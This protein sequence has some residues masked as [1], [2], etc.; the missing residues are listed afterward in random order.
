MKAKSFRVYLVQ[1]HDGNHTG[2]LLRTWDWIFDRPAPSAY[3][4]SEAEVLARLEAE[5]QLMLASGQDDIARYLWDD[6]FELRTIGIDIHPQSPVRG[7]SVIGKRPIPLRITYLWSKVGEA[8]YRIMVPRFSWW[9]IVEDLSIAREVLRQAVSSTLLGESPRSVFHY[10][11]DGTESVKTWAPRSL[12]GR[13]AEEDEEDAFPVTRSVSEELVERAA[14]RKLPLM[15]GESPEL[16][17][18]LSWVNRDPPASLLIVG[19]PGVGKT[20]WVYRLAARMAGWRRIE[21]RKDVPRIW[22]TSASRI[23]AGMMYLGM[24]QKRCLD[25]VTELAY[26]GDYLFVG[27]L[28]EILRSQP[29]GTSIGQ[30]LVE[31]AREGEISLIAECTEEE[32]EALSRRAPGLVGVFHVVRLA[33]PPLAEL[34]SWIELA[35]E[36]RRSGLRLHPAASRRLVHHL[37]TFRPDV[38][39]PGNV[40]RFLDWMDKHEGGGKEK[41]DGPAKTL[42]PR[43]VSEL[44]SK[45]TGLPLTLLADEVPAASESLASDLMRG[46][47]GQDEACRIA[48]SVL[49]RFKAGLNDPERPCA[50]LLFTGPTGV[51]KTELAKQLARTMFGDE[52]RAIR[53]DMSEY[54]LPGSASR[55]LDASPAR[56]SLARRVR[57]QPL[58]LV[59][60]DEIEKAHPEVFDLLLSV[61]GE[62]RLTD[63]DGRVVDFRMSLIV[64]TSNLGALSTQPVGFGDGAPSPGREAQRAARAY[65]RPEFTNRIDHVIGFRCLDREDVQKIVDLEIDKVRARP[66]IARRGISLRVSGEARE[67]LAELG[68]DP[69]RGARG[70]KRVIEERVVAPMAAWM[71]QNPLSS[72]GVV[73]V[74]VDGTGEIVVETS[75]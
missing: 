48:A 70:L 39:F 2:V 75:N 15:V 11:M 74:E 19:P 44:F 5:V 3:G 62:G 14:R 38:A 72:R 33:Q 22:S 9:F 52:R 71:A 69:Q 68:F 67:R 20:T 59:L 53:L 30:M 10:R 27:P 64:M 58:C 24:W 26:E 54:M 51:G 6:D 21:G 40:F 18:A 35:Q 66:G 47:V 45:H 36:R 41:A 43:D 60:F 34:P 61:L 28:P 1:H 57:R 32:L 55:L 12:S 23:L 37:A 42:Y 7:A 63:E 31:A 4:A 17:A 13:R 73:R 8:G 46:V 16:D 65:F 50:T 25:L 49:A 56:D 29:D